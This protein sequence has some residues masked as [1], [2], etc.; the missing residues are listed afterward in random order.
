MPNQF[1]KNM[2]SLKKKATGFPFSAKTTQYFR[3]IDDPLICAAVT[4]R[5]LYLLYS[6]PRKPVF[7]LGELDLS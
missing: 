1:F 5:D 6:N 7:Q 3:D 2:N 4:R